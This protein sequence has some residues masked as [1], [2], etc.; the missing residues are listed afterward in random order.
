MR[1][2][3]ISDLHIGA[4][5]ARF[6]LSED[7]EHIFRQIAELAKEHQPQAIVVAGDIY[8]NSVPSGEAVE[9]FDRFVTMLGEAC[10]EA[11][12]MMISG[13]H[14]SPSRINVF[15]GVLSRQKIHMIGM[16]PRFEG[17]HIEKVTLEDEFG[18]TVFWLLPFVRPSAVRLITGGTDEK[19]S[20]DEAL[21]R[22]LDREDI[23][24]SV[25]NVFVSHQAYIPKGREPG[26]VERTSAEITTVG[27]IDYIRSDILEPF[28]YCALGHFHKP[29]K[30]RG[31][32]CR[33]SGSP[34]AYSADEEGQVKHVVMVELGE[35]GDV[36]TTEL[37]LHPLRK[38]R[39]EKGLLE[40]V[41]S[42]PSDDFVKIVITD[43]GDL[44]VADMQDRLF[45]AFPHLIDRNRAVRPA[46]ERGVMTDDPNDYTEFEH[47]CRFLGEVS[48]EEKELLAD[49]IN[50]VKLG[51]GDKV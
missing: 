46:G 22:L 21:T 3:H 39:T 23:D 34:L 37:P 17:E 32:T 26:D 7:Q 1:F 36:K 11:E 35:K 15:R 51:K 29:T 13:N 41:L 8:D 33:Y 48:D 38:I 43:E 47:C 2:F 24:T 6:D 45:E 40:E 18:S 10:P 31:G 25:R 42:R 9:L 16:P 50:T 14:D 4:R 30:V 49:L 27:N 44:D 28:D 20:Y 5:L 19:L 12:I